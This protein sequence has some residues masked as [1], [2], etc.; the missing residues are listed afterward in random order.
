MANTLWA[1]D[2]HRV[3]LR[4]DSKWRPEGKIYGFFASG[5]RTCHQRFLRHWLMEFNVSWHM[6]NAIWVLDAHQI[7]LR[8]DLKWLP[9]G[10][11]Y[12]FLAL[13]V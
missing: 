2:A 4:L 13:G 10:K 11:I 6:A 1:P 9:G 12:G 8:S 3:I 7:M 5:V